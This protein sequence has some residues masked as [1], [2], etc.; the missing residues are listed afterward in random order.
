MFFYSRSC[1]SAT[2]RSRVRL[3][4]RLSQMRPPLDWHFSAIEIYG[5]R[6]RRRAYSEVTSGGRSTPVLG[7]DKIHQIA[8]AFFYHQSAGSGVGLAISRSIAESHGG[9]LWASPNAGRGATFHFTLSIQ[10]T[11]SSPLLA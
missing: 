8:S 4:E 10:V 5:S 3:R 1:E 11:E 7:R 2:L 9:Q 6:I